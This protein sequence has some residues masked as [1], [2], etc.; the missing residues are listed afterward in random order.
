MNRQNKTA[1]INA[2]V[3]PMAGQ[4][5][6]PDFMQRTQNHGGAY[7]RRPLE[8]LWRTPNWAGKLNGG[9]VTNVVQMARMTS[10]PTQQPHTDRA[11]SGASGAQVR[12][13]GAMVCIERRKDG[14]E[15]W[16][17]DVTGTTIWRK[18]R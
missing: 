1:P 7:D 9:A 18:S 13:D 15:Y 4:Q 8:D 3:V 14:W 11:D 17:D 16:R 5:L 2:R 10:Q 12:T 6:P